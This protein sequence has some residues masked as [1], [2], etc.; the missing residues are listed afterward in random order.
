[1]KASMSLLNSSQAKPGDKETE[2]KMKVAGIQVMQKPGTK[3]GTQILNVSHLL[4]K[5]M[6]PKN[7]AAVLTGVKLVNTQQGKSKLNFSKLLP[8]NL[9]FC[10]VK[11]V[12]TSATTVVQTVIPTPKG[13]S[14]VAKSLQGQST[15]DLNQIQGTNQQIISMEALVQGARNQSTNKGSFKKKLYVLQLIK[16]KYFQVRRV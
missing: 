4:N 7:N 5:P 2:Q 8:R 16:K 14:T 9:I 3:L 15:S 13:T 11:M 6:M 12:A 10:L 1:M